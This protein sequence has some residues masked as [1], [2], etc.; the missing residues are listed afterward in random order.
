LKSLLD[1]L[2]KAKSSEAPNESEQI[3][4]MEE[5]VRKLEAQ[6]ASTRSAAAKKQSEQ[7]ADNA[8]LKS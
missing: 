7:T 1:Q 3:G 6:L 2:T 8:T 5:T 4:L